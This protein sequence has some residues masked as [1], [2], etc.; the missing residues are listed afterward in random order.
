MNIIELLELTQ[1]EKRMDK[2]E[3]MI[4]MICEYYDLKPSHAREILKMMDNMAKDLSKEY[5]CVT[6]EKI[7]N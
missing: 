7:D 4:M 5:E 2:K 3:K 6:K 1:T